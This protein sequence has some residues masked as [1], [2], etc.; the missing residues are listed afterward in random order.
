MVCFTVAV[1]CDDS[2]GCDEVQHPVGGENV[3]L[4]VTSPHLPVSLSHRM[5]QPFD[6]CIKSEGDFE[7]C[8]S[9]DNER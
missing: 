6:H 4:V 1:G 2:V 9:D 3:T 8:L 7:R 5:R